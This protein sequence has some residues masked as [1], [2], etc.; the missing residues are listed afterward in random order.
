[1]C[2]FCDTPILETVWVQLPKYMVID[3]DLNKVV[4]TAMA[5]RSDIK[6]GM[7][8]YGRQA[9]QKLMLHLKCH[10]RLEK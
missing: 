5:N 7:P 3:K 4:E 8:L 10:G 9:S 2:A 1:M 6:Y